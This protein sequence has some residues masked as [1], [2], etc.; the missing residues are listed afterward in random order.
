MKYSV[1]IEGRVQAS[2]GHI[3]STVWVEYKVEI[4]GRVQQAGRDVDKCSP[5]GLSW[6][7]DAPQN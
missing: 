6:S 1:E 3:A 5:S 7:H 4:E 2:E